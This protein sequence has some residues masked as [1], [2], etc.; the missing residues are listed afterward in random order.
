MSEK[1]SNRQGTYAD[2]TGIEIELFE[3]LLQKLYG[4]FKTEKDA[5]NEAYSFILRNGD[6]EAFRK[7]CETNEEKQVDHHAEAR[8]LVLEFFDAQRN[9]SI[10]K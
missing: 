3:G 7:F 8:Q 2:E 1:D 5:K 4:K 9:A 6:F 10:S